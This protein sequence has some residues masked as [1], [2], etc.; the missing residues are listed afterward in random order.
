MHL[1]V[2]QSFAFNKRN[3]LWPL[4]RGSSV[5]TKL[6]VANKG[7]CP[8]SFKVDW[9]KSMGNALKIEPPFGEV[10]PADGPDGGMTQISVTCA[11]PEVGVVNTTVEVTVDGAPHPVPF[12]LAAAVVPQS[13]ELLKVGA[14][15]S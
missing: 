10:G 5:T 15:T 4:R 9:D 1:L 2:S 6:T 8:A 12:D 7:P 3:V 14:C 13:L 11:P